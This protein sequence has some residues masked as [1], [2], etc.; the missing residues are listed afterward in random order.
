M[1]TKYQKPK[2]TRFYYEDGNKISIYF[3]ET[4]KTFGEI[5]AKD[6]YNDNEKHS[7]FELFKNFDKSQEGILKYRE[8]FYLDCQELFQQGIF[9]KKHK[10]HYDAVEKSFKRYGN[11]ELEGLGLVKGLGIR[12]NEVEPVS[13]DEYEYIENCYNGGIIYIAEEYKGKTI[14]SYGYDYTSFYPNILMSQDLYLPK[15][16]GQKV[17][18]QEIDYN[19][20]QYGIYRVNITSDN[21]NVCKV[22]GFSKEGYYTH[23]SLQFAHRY[24][25]EL[26]FQI[27]LRTDCDTNAIVH[28]MNSLYPCSNIFKSWFDKMKELKQKCKGNM[29]VKHLF[30]S[31]WGSLCKLEKRYFNETQFI[32]V[33]NNI[34]HLVNEK[35]FGN[36][37]IRFEF[38]DKR[39]P[40]KYSF[41]RLKSFVLAMAR[42]TIGS[43][44]MENDLLN[45]VF[46]VHTDNL[47]LDC[48]LEFPNDG[49]YYPI[50]E[51]KTT[52]K[53]TW[54]NCNNYLKIS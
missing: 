45:N 44:I 34:Y 26:G 43:L 16:Q 6:R 8:K 48:E 51:Q 19:D 33:D 10:N 29:L 53:I 13:F 14:E 52:G 18:F 27:N 2:P 17:K 30:S 3:D 25:K 24:R 35:I 40:Y 15:T 22:F 46:R 5:T 39:K 50:A 28:D 38:I 21:S 20:L 41:A 54:I 36:G 32:E 23:Y 4:T 42:N 1:S 7:Y 37:V 12:L 49:G 31:L 47:T 11:S 9:Y